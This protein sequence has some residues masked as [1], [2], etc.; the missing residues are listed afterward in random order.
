VEA[1]ALRLTY[2][3]GLWLQHLPHVS[4]PTTKSVVRSLGAERTFTQFVPLPATLED[5]GER[6][7]PRAPH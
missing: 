7:F 2:A 5:F 3:S 4:S 6:T 1:A